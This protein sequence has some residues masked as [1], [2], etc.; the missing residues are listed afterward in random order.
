MGR[1][2]RAF[3]TGIN[4]FVGIHLAD[5]LNKKNW[6]LGGLVLPTDSLDRR[7]RLGRSKLTLWRGVLSQTDKLALI[8]KEFRPR[9]IFHL[10]AQ[11]NV[12]ISWHDPAGTF[13]CNVLGTLSLLEA[14]RRS[15]SRARLISIGSAEEYGRARKIFK[16]TDALEPTSPYAASKAAAET[17][18]RQYRRGL[19]LDVV[20][21]RPFGHIGPGQS[22]IFALASFA[23]QIAELE[24]Q[25]GP[26]QLMVGNLTV[27]RDL[28]DVRDM[29]RAYWLA[30]LKGRSGEVYNIC[31]GRAVKLKDGL[32]K[33]LRRSRRPIGLKIDP[34][35]FRP[36]DLPQ[37]LGSNQKFKRATG[38]RPAIAFDQTIK[39]TLDYWRGQ[40]RLV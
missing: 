15:G 19:G 39:D 36:S 27:W 25:P 12:G 8:L 22:P 29:V 16:E 14:M 28:T 13:D 17:L 38:W 23:K 2:V 18:C 35:R 40:I 6:R 32:T 20:C 37:L 1:P 33:L 5:F 7:F 11:A 34:T 26:R 10:A 30:A 9:Y 3:I 4:G 24:K 31:S 21:L